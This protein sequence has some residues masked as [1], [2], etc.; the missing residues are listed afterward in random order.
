MNDQIQVLETMAPTDFLDFRGYLSS[1]SGFQSLQFRLFENKVGMQDNLRIKY[2]QERYDY[3]FTEKADREQL[4]KSEREPTL[5]RSIDAWLSRTPGLSS[6]DKDNGKEADNILLK[7]YEKSVIQYLTDTYITPA[8]EETCPEDK[9]ALILE[10]KKTL[11]SFETIFSAEKHNKLMDRG[12]RKLSHKALWGALMIWLNRDEP[13][14]H[15]PYQ[16]LS[17][18]TDL[19]AIMNRWRCNFV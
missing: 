17:S 8:E 6:F 13:R 14:F 12:E 3:V 5:L 10:Y 18:L 4:E 1:A 2:N 7:Q 15:L 19:D 16:L 9:E 11:D